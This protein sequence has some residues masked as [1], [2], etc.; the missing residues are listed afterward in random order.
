MVPDLSTVRDL[1]LPGLILLGEVVDKCPAHPHMTTGQLL[2][3]WRNTKNEALLSR[4][5]SWDLQVDDDNQED[6]FID[7]LDRILA[8]CV[9]QQIE[10]AAKERS[11][12]LSVDEKRELLALML[13]LKA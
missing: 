2:E 6:V 12:G 5:A 1:S 4:L 7:S 9:E 13:D 8:Q 11:V 3:H 10:T